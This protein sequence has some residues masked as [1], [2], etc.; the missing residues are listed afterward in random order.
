MPPARR[1]RAASTGKP[2][3]RFVYVVPQSVMT[4]PL[5]TVGDA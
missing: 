1:K 4:P 3:V 2:A 5:A